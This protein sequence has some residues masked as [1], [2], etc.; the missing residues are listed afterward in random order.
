MTQLVQPLMPR[1]KNFHNL[2]TRFLNAKK[3]KQKKKNKKKKKRKIQGGCV[4]DAGSS[5][6]HDTFSRA[7]ANH[8]LRI[9][10]RG[11]F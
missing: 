7:A 6:N 8:S 3:K 9:K 2:P 10:I 11:M 5:Q 4:F 1:Y